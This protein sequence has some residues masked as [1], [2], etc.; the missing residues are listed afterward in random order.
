MGRPDGYLCVVLHAH[1]PFVKHPEHPFFLEENWLYEAMTECYLPLLD[2]FSRLV[3]DGIDFK[4]VLSLSPSLV[5]MLIDPLLMDRYVTHLLRLQALAEA[6]KRRHRRDIRIEPIVRMYEE[7]LNRVR[8]LFE[9]VYGKNLMPVF[10]QLQDQG[11]ILIVPSAATHAY[12]PLLATYPAAVRAQLSIG[13]EQY[14]RHFGSVP[15]GLWLPECGFAPG[16]DGQLRNLGLRFFFLESHGVVRGDPTPRYGTFLPVVCRSGAIA[17]GRDTDAS[18][19][20]WSAHGGYPGDGDYRDFYRDIGFDSD[21]AHVREFLQPYGTRTFTG[22]KYFRV[23]G[24]TD[25]KEPYVAARAV[26]KADEHAVHY[27]MSREH[28]ARDVAARYGIRPVITASFDAELFGHWWFEGPRWLETLLREAHRRGRAVRTVTPA[29]YLRAGAGAAIVQASQPSES[30]W[31]EKGYHDVWLNDRNDTLYRHLLRATGQM[32]DLANRHPCAQGLKRRALDQ[33]AR[34]VLL[35]QHSDWAFMMKNATH[36]A[37]ARM[38]FATHIGRFSQLSAVVESG[39]IQEKA[40][41]DMERSDSI[42]PE[43][44][45]RVFR[46]GAAEPE[47]FAPRCPKLQ[48]RSLS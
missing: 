21:D 22:L 45:Y 24:R 46:S 48:E 4:I 20:V 9:D 30:S 5:E 35:A 47:G 42:F 28:Q 43:I 12:L 26:R 37:Y 18:R 34:E 17:F 16:I 2:V 14:R 27:L 8:E 41:S 10:R 38:R 23:T 1:L 44:D 25:K 19:Q 39:R 36:D 11:N 6:E 13:A 33:A 7:R 15:Q 40:L 32:I 3:N 31:G 29:E